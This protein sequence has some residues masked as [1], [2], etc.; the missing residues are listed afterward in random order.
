MI[1]V[2]TW[3]QWTEAYVREHD[4]W[5]KFNISPGGAANVLGVSRQAVNN[6]INRGRLDAVRIGGG[7]TRAVLV[8]SEGVEAMRLLRST[9]EGSIALV[10]LSHKRRL[11]TIRR[12]R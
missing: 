4:K 2:F 8:D 1:H 10:A 11:E 9:A 6:A 12:M 7:G 5:A 3:V